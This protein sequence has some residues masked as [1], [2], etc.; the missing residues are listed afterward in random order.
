M[1]PASIRWRLQIWFGILLVGLLTAFGTTA[2]QL[3]RTQRIGRLDRDLAE[4]AALLGPAVRSPG[5]GPGGRGGFNGGPGGSGGRGPDGGH[6]N[7]DHPHFRGHGSKDEESR[8]DRFDDVTGAPPPEPPEFREEMLPANSR[9]FFNESSPE[10]FYY[11][12]WSGWFHTGKRSALAPAFIP[13]PDH[14]DKTT[15]TRFRNREG[16]RE[17]YFFTERGDCILAGRPVTQ[18]LAAMRPVAYSL[19]LSGLAIL[20]LGL[21]GGWWLTSLSIRPIEQI[22]SAARRISENNLSERIPPSAPGS[23]LGALADVLNTTFSRLEDSFSQQ[24]RFTSDAS[25]ELRTPLTVLISETQ[26]ALSRERTLEEY[27][28]VLAGNLD[29]ARQMKRLAEALLELAR[30]DAGDGVESLVFDLAIVASERVDRLKTL[31]A[32]KSITLDLDLKPALVQGSPDRFAL[33]VT[34]LLENAIHYGRHGGTVSV[35]TGVAKGQSTLEVRD[36][37]IGIAAEDLPHIFERFYRADRSRSR[38]GGRYGLGLAICRGMI[39]ADGGSIVAESIAGEGSTFRVRFPVI[40]V[41][42]VVETIV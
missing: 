14:G 23:E 8:E 38:S 19:L 1:F 24:K 42:N 34:N 10:G 29:T 30:L 35:T 4:Q 12:I 37:G 28:E 31:A 3:E 16:V 20:A 26:T 22:A 7:P 41:G 17:V 39:T 2:W 33:V 21:G 11:Y 15:Q 36:D 25:H 32:G 6:P 27:K 5:P 13:L 18:D 9:S 40:A